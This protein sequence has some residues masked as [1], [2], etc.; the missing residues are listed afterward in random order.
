MDLTKVKATERK[1]V[2]GKVTA[3]V[4][5]KIDKAVNDIF[6]KDGIDMDD[7]KREISVLTQSYVEKK[8]VVALDYL[9]SR[10]NDV[11][12]F[13]NSELGSAEYSI[14]A[15][16]PKVAEIVKGLRNALNSSDLKIPAQLR[17]EVIKGDMLLLELK[18]N[19]AKAK[20][21][22]KSSSLLDK[23]SDTE[24][25]VLVNVS[26]F[27]TLQK[28]LTLD[29]SGGISTARVLSYFSELLLVPAIEISNDAKLIQFIEVS[30]VDVE[31]MITSVT[32]LDKE[33]VV[34]A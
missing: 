34:E 12:E 9:H 32:E 11:V 25:D 15:T 6:S 18:S 19:F 3:T 7:A 17:V 16:Y 13:L 31:G 10:L 26:D 33:E 8:N 24:Y 29:Y 27:S 1:S 2:H 22:N 4:G 5:N 21:N 14:T 30:I 28:L 20:N 23:N